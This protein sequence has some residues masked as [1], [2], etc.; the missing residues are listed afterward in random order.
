MILSE[1]EIIEKLETIDTPMRARLRFALKF[2]TKEWK[3]TVEENKD[4]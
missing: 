1:K 4:R 3:K 2:F